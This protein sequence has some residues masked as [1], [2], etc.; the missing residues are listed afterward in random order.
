MQLVNIT[1]RAIREDKRGFIDNNLPPILDRLN[2]SSHEWLVLT[3]Q[4][5]SKFKSLVGGK[6]KLLLAAKALGLQRRPAYANCEAI[7]H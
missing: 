7:L 1:G 5:E 2:I 3:T 6:E 4:F